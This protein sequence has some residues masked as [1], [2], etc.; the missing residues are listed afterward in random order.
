M[1]EVVN[2]SSLIKELEAWPLRTFRSCRSGPSTTTSSSPAAQDIVMDVQ[3]S[4]IGGSSVANDGKQRRRKAD[5]VGVA[6]MHPAVSVTSL[7]NASKLR[8]RKS[9]VVV[10]QWKLAPRSWLCPS[11]LA[12]SSRARRGCLPSKFRASMNPQELATPPCASFLLHR[13]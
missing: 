3:P 11:S 5:V 6:S 2:P 12:P 8:A 10:S 13:I 1:A 4:G 7:V 9:E